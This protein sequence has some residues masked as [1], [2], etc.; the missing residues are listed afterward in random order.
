MSVKRLAPLECL[1]AFAGAAH[2]QIELGKGQLSGSLE[3]NSIYYVKDNG[4]RGGTT[5]ED[6]FGSNNYLKVDYSLGR[7]SAGIQVD[8]YQIGR[9]HV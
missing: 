2:A 5:P 3:S 9:A 8:A 6:R 1:L 4:F 7:F